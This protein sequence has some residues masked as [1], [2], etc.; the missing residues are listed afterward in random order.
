MFNTL[1][2][3]IGCVP[4][5]FL[6][7]AALLVLLSAL[8]GRDVHRHLTLSPG[9][10]VPGSGSMRANQG[11]IDIT[12]RDVV[13][14]VLLF[15]ARSD[16]PLGTVDDAAFRD[17]VEATLADAMQLPA[18]SSIKSYYGTADARM[19][20]DRGD[21]TYATLMLERGNDDGMAAYQEL[22]QRLRAAPAQV[23]LGGQL[24]A[25]FDA[26]ERLMADVQYAEMI[27]F[28]A[29]AALLLWVFGSVVAALLPLLTGAITIA[30]S[31]ALLKACA[32]WFD[33][34]V[35]AA[36]VV[37]MLGLGLSIDYALFMVSR[38][39]EE[40]HAGRDDTSALQIT[41]ATAGRTVAFS[42][43]TVAV[44]LFCLVIL[45]QRFFQNIGLAGGISVAA[46]MLSSIFIL[47]ALLRLFWRRVDW[48]GLPV[49]A[50]RAARHE[51]G[52]RWLGFSLF[53]LRHPWKM[54]LASLMIL[55][56]IGLPATHLEISASDSRVL[57]EGTESRVVQETLEQQF[58]DAELTPVILVLKTRGNAHEGAGIVGV[59]D[60]THALEALPLVERVQSLTTLIVDMGAQEYAQLYRYPDS[61]PG[62]RAALES[63]AAGDRTLALVWYRVGVSTLEARTLVR[64]I[65]AM[66]LPE[67]VESM[68]TGGFAAA[69][70][71]YVD[72]LFDGIPWVVLA[73]IGVVLVLL[74]LMLGSVLLPVKAVLTNLVSLSA[75]I[76]GLV[77][78]FQD[79]H[80]ATW[81]GFT[82]QAGLE[83]TVLMLVFASAFGL[84]I[85]YELFLVSRV[86]EACTAT[87]DNMA[88]IAQGLTQSGPIITSAA[89]LIGIVLGTFAMGELVFM[90][91]MG[92]GLLISVAIDA[93]LVRMLLVPATLR[94]LG[95]GN[96]WAP[97]TLQRLH[98]RIGIN[99]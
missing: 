22:R 36:N 47:P 80:L 17:A 90:K 59:H 16:V 38:Y 9:W 2:R 19:R 62:A 50:R 77:W 30:L 8:Y 4:W 28:V 13:P 25:D 92:L 56:F 71:D 53:V 32:Q 33:V 88:A 83:G 85:D 95:R 67:G 15:S 79:G 55:G 10:D 58:P 96:W 39:R 46:A 82:P 37:S 94:L 74:F 29:L 93:T 76:G 63:F 97:P 44:S 84:S 23:R 98:Q 61:F 65:R 24:A 89:L 99:H 64:E 52:G 75:T 66:P 73:I 21:M 42:G 3:W 68:A 26:R 31:A 5:F 35:Y 48:L 86:K 34:N 43:L 72:A 6:L 41:L 70:Q 57:P 69:Q 11:L 49:L 78:L 7:M 87:G 27:S 12:G 45:P 81:L 51:H 18:V 91:A 54:L 14:V 20:S 60:L 40:L 1:W